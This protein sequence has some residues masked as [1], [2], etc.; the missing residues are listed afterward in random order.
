VATELI[1]E[2]PVKIQ[3]PSTL[4][5]PS[6]AYLALPAHDFSSHHCA[7]LGL[8]LS[9]QAD[10]SID[11]LKKAFSFFIESDSTCPYR[12]FLGGYA[13]PNCDGT[14]NEVCAVREQG[15]S[16]LRAGPL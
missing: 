9:R 7:D 5:A 10:S 4:P 2:N 13:E 6:V 8:G 14:H 12:R 1:I 11:N 16:A 15:S 3:K